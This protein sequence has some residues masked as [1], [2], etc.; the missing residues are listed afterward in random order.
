MYASVIDSFV[1][2][3]QLP[4]ALAEPIK[5][6]CRSYKEALIQK[7]GGLLPP[8]SL[9]ILDYFISLVVEELQ[10]PNTFELYHQRVSSPIDYYRFGLDIMRP[11]IDFERS[12]VA[13]W[14][15]VD[16]ISKQVQ[17]GENVILLAN[18]QIEPD[19]QV[20]HLMLEEK[21]P[22]LAKQMIFI[23]G[24]RV[25]TDPLA[26]P[27]SKGCNLLC[28]YSKKYIENPPELKAEKQQRNQKTMKKMQQLL[29]EGGEC[30]YVAPSGGRDRMNASGIVELAPFD[31]QSIEL[32]WLISQQVTP[33]THFYPLALSTYHLMPP[34]DR[35]NLHLG[36]H[37]YAS[38]SPVHLAFGDEVDMSCFP[39]H[40]P[41]NKRLN[42]QIRADFIFK[43]IQDAYNQFLA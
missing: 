17:A 23:A 41:C 43:T 27:F 28:I 19:P 42:R 18:H 6:F 37:R 29:E 10:H 22:D 21:Y 3:G 36:E 39:G 16:S 25:V 33:K 35:V 1:S 8:N 30:I 31:P 11:L 32:F 24:Q 26:I 7:E 12:T 20:I 38:Y 2:S 13:N 4:I 15:A 9:N 5:N 14:N 40:D 34:P